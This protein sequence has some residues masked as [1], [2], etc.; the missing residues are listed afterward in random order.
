MF[1][2]VTSMPVIVGVGYL[3]Y[4][5][6]RAGYRGPVSMAIAGAVPRGA[7][8]DIIQQWTKW[9]AMQF[10]LS[11][12]FSISETLLDNAAIFTILSFFCI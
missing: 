4:R 10:S 11:F 6:C 12:H 5:C 9:V 7:A 2:G 3:I 8:R 1:T